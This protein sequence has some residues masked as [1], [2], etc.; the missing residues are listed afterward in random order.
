M[1][2]EDGVLNLLLL[3]IAANLAVPLVDSILGVGRLYFHRPGAAMLGEV[4]LLVG[5][6]AG[7]GAPVA[8]FILR[9]RR[10]VE[11]VR[12][13]QFGYGFLF[14]LVADRAG[15]GFD[16][17]CFLGRRGSHFALVPSMGR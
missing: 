13:G 14:C 5:V 7:S 6:L 15:I 9:P 2:R 11:S 10:H 16:A 1:S 17:F 8:R 3:V 12:M 4:F